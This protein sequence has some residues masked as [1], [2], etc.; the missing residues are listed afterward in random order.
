MSKSPGCCFFA[1]TTVALATLAI[2]SLVAVR[3]ISADEQCIVTPA[4]RYNDIQQKS[5]HDSYDQAESLLDQLNRFNLRS[6][7][8][9]IHGRKGSPAPG[10][11]WFVYHA[12][13][14]V[15]GD[16][17]PHGRQCDRLSDCLAKLRKFHDA[18]P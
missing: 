15:R 9:D 12:P 14:D 11:D 18:S 16:K 1:S 4:T 3:S 13:L 6:L 8:I 5:G 7:E 17:V 2:M 10:G